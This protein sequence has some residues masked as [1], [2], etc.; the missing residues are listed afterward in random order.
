MFKVYQMMRKGRTEIYAIA[1][2]TAGGCTRDEYPR[3]CER[4]ARSAAAHKHGGMPTEWKC[5]SYH[6]MYSTREA[7]ETI[8]AHLG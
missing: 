5:V 4:M 2:Q 6:G 1:A 7:A 3:E 8:A